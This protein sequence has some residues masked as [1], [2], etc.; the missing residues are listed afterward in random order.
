M[1]SHVFLFCRSGG[2]MDIDE[3][4]NRLESLA[5][6]LIFTVISVLLLAVI[7]IAT[8]HGPENSGWWTRPALAPGVALGLL[9]FANCLTLWRE[10]ADLRRTPA[11]VSE[12][13]EARLKIIGWLRPIEYLAYFSIYLFALQHL[14]YFPATLVFILGLL[15]R[16]GLRSPRWLLAGA[17]TSVALVLVFR[18][19]LGVWMP[20]PE[21]YD[22]FPNAMRMAL[23]RW[24]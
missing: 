5:L 9:A 21:V 24:F 23:I 11:T 3:Q 6:T 17:L 2:R 14:G 12:W 4:P 16:S 8:R 13:A 18:V 1:I 10:L 15:V 7:A 19:G 22:L 20:A